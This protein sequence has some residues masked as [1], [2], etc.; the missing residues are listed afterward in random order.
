MKYIWTNPKCLTVKIS[1]G[2]RVHPYRLNSGIGFQICNP[3]SSMYSSTL[4]V[5]QTRNMWSV[6]YHFGCLSDSIPWPPWQFFCLDMINSAMHCGVR[7]LWFMSISKEQCVLVHLVYART[8]SRKACVSFAL[9]C[10]VE[11]LQNW[12]LIFKKYKKKNAEFYSFQK[13][14]PNSLKSLG[15]LIWFWWVLDQHLVITK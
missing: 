4:K 7:T 15:T 8:N 3:P 10:F 6:I 5:F 14:G 2:R 12:I 9:V 11:T 1:A 13:P